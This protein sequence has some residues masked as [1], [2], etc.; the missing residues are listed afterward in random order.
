[1]SAPRSRWI[2]LVA[3]VAALVG[4]CAP[5]QA[6]A[7]DHGSSD[8]VLIRGAGY[9]RA[10]G[11]AR[12]RAV[13]RHLRAAGVDPGPVDG[14]YGPSTEVAVRRFQSAHG[15]AVDGIVGSRTMP[16]VR[17]PVPLARGAGTGLS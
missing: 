9:D 10:A 11:S 4:L 5:H 2:V 7:A 6:V 17:A 14:R 12:V 13:Q 15:L 1:M 3:A 16:V 8:V